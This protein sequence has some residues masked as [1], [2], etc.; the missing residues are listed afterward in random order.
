MD[1]LLNQTKSDLFLILPMVQL[2]L[3]GLGVLI[4]DFLLEARYKYW[5]AVMAM[6]GVAFSG[7]SLWRL[8]AILQAT[9]RAELLGFNRSLVID[10]FFI[11]FSMIFLAS[12]ALVI[13]LSVRFMEIEEEHRSEE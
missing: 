8:Y 12:T 2:S 5:N 11:F 6:L 4:T 3:F 9:G 7:F 10:N 1:E 13:L